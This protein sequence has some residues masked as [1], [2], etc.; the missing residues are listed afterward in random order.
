LSQKAEWG[1]LVARIVLGVVMLAHGLQKFM[2]M[3]GMVKMFSEGFGLPGFLAYVTAIIETVGGAALILGVFVEVSA[4]A[5][6]LLMIGATLTVKMPM[7][8]G[9]FGNM[10][11]MPMPGYELDLAILGLSV[12]LAL[13]GS[14]KW[15][16][17]SIFK[18]NSTT[19]PEV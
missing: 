1:L 18:S 3:D 8:L 17:S 7:G 16:L 2:M 10:E 19:S 13:M 12:V 15:A 9:L 11:K 4:I 14:R 5:I 6:G